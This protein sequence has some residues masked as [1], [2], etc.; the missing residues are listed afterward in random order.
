MTSAK[1]MTKL[2]RKAEKA[3]PRKAKNEEKRHTRK[4]R[5]LINRKK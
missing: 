5:K 3:S 1:T 2:H 4:L